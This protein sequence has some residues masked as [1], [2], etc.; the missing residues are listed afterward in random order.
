MRRASVGN[1]TCP[2]VSGES[3]ERML[4]RARMF[5]SRC[6]MAGLRT[7]A[8]P[9][10]PLVQTACLPMKPHETHLNSFGVTLEPAAGM[11]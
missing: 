1:G 7:A 6:G 4:M 10:V 9:R 3:R 11:V 8:V 5:A 2:L